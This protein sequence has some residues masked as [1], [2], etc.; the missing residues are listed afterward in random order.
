M[1]KINLEEI[2]DVQLSLRSFTSTPKSIHLAAMREACEKTLDLAAE[3]ISN[4]STVTDAERQS[5]VRSV[6]T[7]IV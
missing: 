2:L 6:K 7:L 5:L 3:H 4:C 1:K